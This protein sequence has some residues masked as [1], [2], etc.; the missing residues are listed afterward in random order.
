[1]G[2][3]RGRSLRAVL[4]GSLVVV[5]LGAS[6]LAATPAAAKTVVGTGVVSCNSVS[7]TITYSAP[8]TDTG[9]GTIHATISLTLTGCSG[10]TP[11]PT[12]VTVT[13][14]AKFKNGGG[15][16]SSA[17][18]TSV[19]LK[20]TYSPALKPSKVK[21]SAFGIQGGFDGLFTKFYSYLI[22]GFAVSGSYTAPPPNAI[23]L[24]G[25][26]VGNCASG[27]TSSNM[28]AVAPSFIV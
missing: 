14:K 3:R 22:P 6:V 8:W 21:S 23:A 2:A 13:G 27:L 15:G 4:A 1:M 10:G 11:T 16:C 24:F 5:G 9:S 26:P 18:N 25:Q 12:S 19:H 20:L 28:Y 7:G 17:V